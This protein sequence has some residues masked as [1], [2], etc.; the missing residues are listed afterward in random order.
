MYVV[1]TMMPRISRLPDE[2]RER[3]DV[4]SLKVVWHL[5]A[6]CPPWLKEAWIEWLGA[7]AIWELYAGTEAQS[8]DDHHRRRSGS[9]IAARSAGPSAAR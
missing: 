9:S 5:A 2:V 1:P 7:D 8:V 3:Y 6:P 4:S